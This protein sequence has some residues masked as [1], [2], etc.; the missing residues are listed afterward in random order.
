MRGIAGRWFKSFLSDRSQCV[1]IR[2]N[3]SDL[4]PVNCGVP[5]GSTLGP[6]LFLLNINDLPNVLQR[7]T[8]IVFADDTCV[9]L[10]GDVLDNTISVLKS[11]MQDLFIWLQTNKLSLNLKKTKSMLWSLSP[12]TKTINP[13]IV[14]NDNYIERVNSIRF[15]GIIFDDHLSWNEHIS[16]IAN[17]ISCSIGVI[18]K[19]KPLY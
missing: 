2:G 9:F 18:G 4:L 7:S 16:Y 14:I 8:P 13:L 17:K 12:T 19:V 5:Q 1:K 10:S 11:E 3:S 6:L 15:L